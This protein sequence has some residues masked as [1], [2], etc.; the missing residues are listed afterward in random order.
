MSKHTIALEV[1]TDQLRHITD[2]A[3]VAYWHA[4]QMSPAPF[5]DLDACRLVEAIGREIIRRFIVATPPPLWNHQGAHINAKHMW[6]ASTAEALG[7]HA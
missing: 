6:P 7:E 5:G 2:E 4:A 1:D 3:L